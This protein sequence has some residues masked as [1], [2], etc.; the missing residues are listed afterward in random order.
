MRFLTSIVGL[1]LLAGLIL[2]IA[3]IALT[4]VLAF[5]LGLGWLLSRLFGFTLFEGSV[6]ALMAGAITAGGAIIFLR[7]PS[8]SGSARSSGVGSDDEDDDEGFIVIPPGRF[9]ATSG[10]SFQTW[11]EYEL[12][13]AIYLAFQHE[14]KQV[15]FMNASQQQELAIRL[16]QSAVAVLK[17]KSPRGSSLQ[18]TR[19]QIER[20]LRQTGQMPY[21]D[22]LMEI[23]VG[24]VN[25][26]V[27]LNDH[28]YE[29][30]IK[31]RLWNQPSDW[32][33]DEEDSE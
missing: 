3:A 11:C 9:T 7:G 1:A 30:I 28:D 21:D 26:A 6:L 12:S 29:H 17:G 18:I 23:A 19:A 4:V 16:G 8:P 20:Q 25:E 2:L 14:P 32:W 5:G 15:A 10:R 33:E 27:A 24:A 31:M 13:N 22:A